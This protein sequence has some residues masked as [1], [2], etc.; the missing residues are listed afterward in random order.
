M[1]DPIPDARPAVQEKP[2]LLERWLLVVPALVIVV[3]LYHLGA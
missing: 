1:K 2:S 3:A